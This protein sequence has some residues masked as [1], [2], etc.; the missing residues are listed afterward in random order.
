MDL[1]RAG[2]IDPSQILIR[3]F[4]ANAS[5]VYAHELHQKLAL[6]DRQLC[7]GRA[8]RLATVD[9]AL[10]VR[11]ESA[12][13]FGLEVGDLSKAD[14][15]LLGRERLGESTSKLGFL[16]QD[17]KPLACPIRHG[18]RNRAEERWRHRNPASLDDRY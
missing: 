2:P 12:N 13:G 6:L 7:H 18:C 8:A 16:L 4:F 10:V 15:V 1:L 14:L 11:N 9:P 3:E 17:L 5:D